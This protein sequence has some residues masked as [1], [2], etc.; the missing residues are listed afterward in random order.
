MQ[1]ILC[2]SLGDNCPNKV[3]NDVVVRDLL[4]TGCLRIDIVPDDCG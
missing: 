3:L 1:I 2:G 4:S